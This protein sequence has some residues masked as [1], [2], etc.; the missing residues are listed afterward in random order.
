MRRSQFGQAVLLKIAPH[1]GFTRERAGFFIAWAAF[2][3]SEALNNPFDTTE[4][5]D[6]ATDYNSVGVKNYLTWEDGV[7][8]TVRTLVNG[9]Y[10]HFLKVL[11]NEKSTVRELLNALDA[12]PWGSHPTTLLYQDVMLEYGKYDSEVAG[13]PKY[14]APLIPEI[15]NTRKEETVSNENVEA[16]P[17]DEVGSVTV[18]DSNAQTEVESAAE[19]TLEKRVATQNAAAG[20]T[21]PVVDVP[22]TEVVAPEQAVVPVV[23]PNEDT[24]EKRLAAA[25]LAPTP[26]ET[27]TTNDSFLAE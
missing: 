23:D 2:E 17:T 15:V 10:E 22:P 12:T 13:S 11:R 19:D 25:G 8:A 21:A 24:L 18:T 27:E 9:Y 3:G 14:V 26:V 1:V 6:G 7:D 16:Q 4:P 20:I 5:Y